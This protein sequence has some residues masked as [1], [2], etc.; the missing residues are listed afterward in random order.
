MPK[1]YVFDDEM[2]T[3]IVRSEKPTGFSTDE[4]ELTD[5]ELK[6]I[7][8]A[9]EAM[10]DA[11]ALLKIKLFEAF[12]EYKILEIRPLVQEA[13]KRVASQVGSP[14]LYYS[15]SG[16]TLK[17]NE[18]CTF[19]VPDLEPIVL[20]VTIFAVDA[21]FKLSVDI[22]GE[23]SGLIHWSLDKVVVEGFRLRQA[24]DRAILN[25]PEPSVIQ[26]ILRFS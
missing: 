18:Y 11:Q 22:V 9:E 8:D 20:R 3:Y 2:S 16:T 13:L 10:A 7:E 6:S 23:E 5:A 1:V 21:M 25:L 24:V 14:Y 17:L 15:T 12:S 19:T 26:G 4:I